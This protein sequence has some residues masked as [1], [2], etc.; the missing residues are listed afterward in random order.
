M[1][2][3]LAVPEGFLTLVLKPIKDSALNIVFFLKCVLVFSFINLNRLQRG[4]DKHTHTRTVREREIDCPFI[5][6]LPICLQQPGLGVNSQEFQAGLS[7]VCQGLRHLGYHVLPPR[8][9]SRQLYRRQWWEL[10]S[11]AQ[12]WDVGTPSMGCRH[13]TW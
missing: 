10:I 6:L 1:A 2:K 12:V 7:Y 5:G 4:K 13:P 9:F 11:S 3:Y 8:D